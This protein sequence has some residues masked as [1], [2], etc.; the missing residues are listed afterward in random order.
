MERKIFVPPSIAPLKSVSS[1]GS[2]ATC[3][4]VLFTNCGKGERVLTPRAAQDDSCTQTT[5]VVWHPICPR[6][7]TTTD[8]RNKKSRFFAKLILYN[9]ITILYNE[10]V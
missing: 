3:G 1:R 8:P 2:R 9:A 10:S 4:P 5:S 6:S 7:V